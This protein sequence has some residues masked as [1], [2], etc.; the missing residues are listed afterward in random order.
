MRGLTYKYLR[1]MGLFKKFPFLEKIYEFLLRLSWKYPSIVEI[2]G[3]KMLINIKE[4]NFNLRRTLQDYAMYSIHEPKTTE[5]F[6]KIVKKGDVVIDCG[7]NIGYFSLLAAKLRATVTAFEPEINN[8]NYLRK[9]TYI[10][11]YSITSICAA[12]SNK[13]GISKFTFSSK[14]SGSHYLGDD[15]GVNVITVTLDSLFGNN[16]YSKVDL[17]KLDIEGAEPL[18]Y[19]GMKSVIKHN[20]QLKMIIEYYPEAINRMCGAGIAGKFLEQLKRDFSVFVIGDYG[21]DHWNLFCCRSAEDCTEAHD[22]LFKAL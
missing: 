18:A 2:Q 19:E 15:G 1:G 20:P 6:K 5:L 16:I 11:N 7:A 8:C 10:N 14:D 21:G 13:N 4:P 12:V 17:V 9:N 22:R 3:S